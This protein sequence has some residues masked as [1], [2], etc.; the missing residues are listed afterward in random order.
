MDLEK[1]EPLEAAI[2]ASRVRP[3]AAVVP[4]NGDPHLKVA[5]VDPGFWDRVRRWQSLGWTI[6]IHGH[7]HRYVTSQA[8]LVGINAMSEF[9]GVP[10]Q[11]QRRKLEEGLAVFRKEG[12]DPT[13]F[14]AP[15]HSFD[16]STLL[17]LRDLAITTIS[18][19]FFLGPRRDDLG[20]LWIP[21]Q[22]W[23]FRRMPAGVWTV[24]V[25]PNALSADGVLATLKGLSA[26]RHQIRSADE[27][28]RDASKLGSADDVMAA[29]MRRALAV[30]RR[31]GGRHKHGIAMATLTTKSER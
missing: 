13:V 7:R 10:I 28:S 6:A 16:R 4:D 5:P 9:A 30:K 3:I 27:V 19:G 11:E 18:D 25:H 17:S 24:C 21:Q 1:W 29:A 14:V 26:Y 15:G 23:Q 8:G 12:V 2:V 31:F 22:L 20:M